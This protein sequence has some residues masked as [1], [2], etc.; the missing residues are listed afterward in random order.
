VVAGAAGKTDGSWEV[1]GGKNSIIIYT[2][3]TIYT[4]WLKKRPPP[5]LYFE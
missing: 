2:K 1:A 5:D 3:Y 4:L